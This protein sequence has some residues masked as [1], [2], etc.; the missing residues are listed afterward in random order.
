MYQEDGG[1]V[2]RRGSRCRGPRWRLFSFVSSTYGRYYLNFVRAALRVLS[3]GNRRRQSTMTDS[4]ANEDR[5]VP[6]PH[7]AAD[8]ARLLAD[9]AIKAAYDEMADEF[10]ALRA[11]LEE[12]QPGPI[13]C[14]GCSR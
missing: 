14:N 12:N 13:G 8:T 10:A 3:A 4:C 7:T 6:V 5:Y 1:S 2:I 9:P 11:R